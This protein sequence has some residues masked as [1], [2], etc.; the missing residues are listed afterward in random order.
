MHDALLIPEILLKIL[1]FSHSAGDVYRFA[2][3]CRS[4]A[5]VAL[6][7]LWRDWSVPL[8]GILSLLPEDLW[9]LIPSR[10]GRPGQITLQRHLKPADWK[11]ILDIGPWVKDLIVIERQED[12]CPQQGLKTYQNRPSPIRGY[13]KACLS[14]KLIYELALH[15]PS[16]HILPNL[17]R[18]RCTA[19][20]KLII[21]FLC[22]SIHSIELV[23]EGYPSGIFPEVEMRLSSSNLRSL[24]LEAEELLHHPNLIIGELAELFGWAEGLTD[25]TLTR[26]FV[27][28]KVF[29]ALSRLPRLQALRI[30]GRLRGGLLS[31]FV[32][33]RMAVHD[34]GV[35]RPETIEPC[36]EDISFPTLRSLDLVISATATKFFSHP[37]CIS[38]SNL[39][40]LAITFNG[41]LV[42]DLQDVI[43]AISERHPGLRHLNI[44]PDNEIYSFIEADGR[45]RDVYEKP[46]RIQRIIRSL[47]TPD[48]FQ[49]LLEL[50]DLEELFLEWP[51]AAQLDRDA[52]QLAVAAWPNIVSLY[53]TPV[54]FFILP[55]RPRIHISSLRSIFC[56]A[57]KLKK[58]ALFVDATKELGHLKVEQEERGRTLLSGL[59]EFDPGRSWISDRAYVLDCLKKACP[60]VR[61][62]AAE[63]RATRWGDV[64]RALK[65]GL[66]IITTV[67][68]IPSTFKLRP[69]KLGLGHPHTW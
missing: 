40:S 8:E 13:P 18:L 58:L 1:G 11:R 68:S 6:E 49:P 55:E 33:R 15:R 64:A 48:F 21:L 51:Y 4:V 60:N 50:K 57:T 19:D 47:I 25:V 63:R 56:S 22:P 7:V 42:K 28:P 16:L 67:T 46:H 24:K 66:P 61:L 37:R 38:S 35:A 53:I 10:Q 41:N 12:R 2:L 30:L 5:G 43:A 59:E 9:D 31:D 44:R 3:V 62:P 36:Q 23:S 54:P 69:Y 27:E 29:T 32:V 39:T 17:E 20:S 65:S 34:K 45:M 52:M 14:E 26:I